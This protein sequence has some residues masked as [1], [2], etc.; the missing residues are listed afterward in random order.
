MTTLFISDLHLTEDEPRVADA[1]I[2]FVDEYARQAEALYILGDF[3]E[4]WLGDDDNTAFNRGIIDALAAL[5]IDKYIMHGNRDFLIGETFCKTAGLT[6]LPDPSV[7]D[8]YGTKVLL[9]HGD[10]LC[11][12]DEQYMTTRR[13]LRNSAF[14]QELLSQP[15]EVRASIAKGARD[16]S[17][18]HTRETALE[19]MDVT[20]DEV[21]SELVSHG[22]TLLVHG[23]THR[24]AIHEHALINNT[25]GTR[26]VLGDWNRQA[27]YLRWD[28]NGY[29]LRSYDI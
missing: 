2:S 26:I 24:P 12:R 17:K 21:I 11:T 7:L 8:I 29:D 23:H 28:D 25:S 20:P 6:L 14:Q 22:T 18:A 5:P 1:F 15:L 27:W 16:K 3:F 10:S 9:M 13:M 19:I 4:V